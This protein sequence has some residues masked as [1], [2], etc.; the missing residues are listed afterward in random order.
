[1]GRALRSQAPGHPAQPEVS[2]EKHYYSVTFMTKTKTWVSGSPPWPTP[3]TGLFFMFIHPQTQALYEI[4]CRMNVFFFSIFKRL[5]C[6]VNK[7]HFTSH[8]LT[9]FG[10]VCLGGWVASFA[11]QYYLKHFSPFGGV[12][13]GALDVRKS[14]TPVGTWTFLEILFK[15]YIQII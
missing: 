7:L 2:E 1:M 6:F 3:P 10:F 4:L 5:K 12:F 14:S 15:A 9:W 8:K 11:L 13:C